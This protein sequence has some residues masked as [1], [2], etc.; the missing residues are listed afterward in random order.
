MKHKT[1]KKWLKVLHVSKTILILLSLALIYFLA[2]NSITFYHEEAHK[3]IFATY[4]IKST[5]TQDWILGGGYT[6][7]EKK[8]T[9]QCDITQNYNEIIGYHMSSLVFNIWCMLWF[10]LIIVYV[11]LPRFNEVR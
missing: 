2:E 11:I 8:C 5:I 7:P 6:S 3:A 10:Y 9:A 4:G 1:A